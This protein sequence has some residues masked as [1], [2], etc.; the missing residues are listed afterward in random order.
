VERDSLLWVACPA[1]WGHTIPED[2]VWVHDH[3][4]AGVWVNVIAHIT[5]KDHVDIP[6]LGCHGGPCWYPKAVTSW[7][8]PSLGCG[9]LKSWSYLSLT[10]TLGRAYTAPHLGSPVDLALVVGAWRS[11]PQGCEQG[12]ACPAPCQPQHWVSE[13]G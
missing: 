10:A 7:P 12:K 6:G 8:H 2:H 1:T 9:T 4:A 5:T 13:P 3:A 11:G